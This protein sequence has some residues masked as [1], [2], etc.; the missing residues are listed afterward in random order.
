MRLVL[1]R[2]TPPGRSRSS[3]R[4]EQEPRQCGEALT[5]SA[6]LAGLFAGLLYLLPWLMIRLLTLLAGFVI[7]A[8]L[9]RLALVVL[10]HVNLQFPN[11][12]LNAITQT[13]VLTYGQRRRKPELSPNIY[14]RP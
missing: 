6:L 7:V 13:T 9:L 8:A 11:Y 3:E 12:N 4:L 5:N 2:L 14:I 10:A 1:P